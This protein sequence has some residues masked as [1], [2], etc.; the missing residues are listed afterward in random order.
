MNKSKNKLISNWTPEQKLEAVFLTR[1]MNEQELGEYL[2]KN[3]L[4]SNDL[5]SFKKDAL[6]G[7]K[8]VGRPKHDPEIAI[9]KK[10]Q[11]KLEREIKRKDK[12]LAEY[13]ARVILLKKSHEIWGEPED[14]E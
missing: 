3:G 5:E 12:A 7:F 14:D 13:S 6:A 1:S 11:V 8:T 4:H 10:K 2:R 9:L